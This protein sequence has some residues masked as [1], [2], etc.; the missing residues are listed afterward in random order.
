MPYTS[1]SEVG[2]I[3]VLRLAANPDLRRLT[4][5]FFDRCRV[6]PDVADPAPAEA[7]WAECEE[8]TE[9]PHH[10]E[11]SGTATLSVC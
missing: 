4:G 8:L 7:F 9:A 10:V 1:R 5:R 6:A 11:E 3:P 2:A